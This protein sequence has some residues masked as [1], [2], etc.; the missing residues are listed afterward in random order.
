MT[1]LKPQKT[2]ES[3]EFR[4]VLLKRLYECFEITGNSWHRWKPQKKTAENNESA[5]VRLNSDWLSWKCYMNHWKSLDVAGTAE[6]S[7]KPLKIFETAEFRW[8]L[9]KKLYESWEITRNSQ[10]R[11]KK[12]WKQLN[13]LDSDGRYWKSCMNHWK[14]QEPVDTAE[15]R[16]KEIENRRIRWIPIGFIE[17]LYESLEIT[18]NS[19]HSWAAQKHR[20]KQLNSLNHNAFDCKRYMN[21]AKSP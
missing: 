8:A 12:R 3:A 7:S 16:W 10:H 19:W 6:N 15:N 20:W 2:A 18:G 14:L 17:K 5:D 4:L 13:P 9:L 1:P 21:H 11:W